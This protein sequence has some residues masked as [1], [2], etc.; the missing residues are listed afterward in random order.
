MQESSNSRSV[1]P[2]PLLLQGCTGWAAGFPLQVSQQSPEPGRPS[3]LGASRSYPIKVFFAHLLC[4]SVVSSGG[5]AMM[6]VP[7]L[8]HEPTSLPTS[9]KAPREC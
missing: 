1:S 8:W 5:I 7:Q 6:L 2:E 4:P 3:E 9:P